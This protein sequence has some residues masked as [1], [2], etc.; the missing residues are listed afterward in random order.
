MRNIKS[1]IAT[2]LITV[3]IFGF[4]GCSK[5]TGETMIRETGETPAASV[6]STTA[7]HTAANAFEGQVVEAGSVVTL[8]KY[9]R[10]HETGNTSIEWIVLKVDGDKALLISKSVIDAMPYNNDPYTADNGEVTWENCTLR[11]WLNND[12]YNRA[13][14]DEER[15]V[16]LTVTLEN[17]DNNAFGTEGGADTEDKVFILSVAEINEYYGFQYNDEDNGIGYNQKL[18]SSPV[19]ELVGGGKCI[20]WEM[21]KNYYEETYKAFGYSEDVIGMK[22]A[23]WWTRTPGVAGHADGMNSCTV[24]KVNE[25]GGVGEKYWRAVFDEKGG[26]RPV[27]WVHI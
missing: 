4:S 16:I 26:V 7:A 11:A 24:V 1:M 6:E 18:I 27:I 23:E 2:I 15:A 25:Y 20:M 8:G 17:P 12:F 10:G 21:Y 22:G 13:F 14:T 19:P 3:M 9:N 5:N